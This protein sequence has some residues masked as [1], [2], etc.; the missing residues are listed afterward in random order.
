MTYVYPTQ[1]LPQAQSRSL[2]ESLDV[3]K[4]VRYVDRWEVVLAWFGGHGLHVF[5]LDGAALDYRTV[6]DMSL[7]DATL[8]EIHAASRDYC[9]SHDS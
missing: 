2:A 6:G 1:E 5:G 3:A 7:D 4:L 8:V 9:A